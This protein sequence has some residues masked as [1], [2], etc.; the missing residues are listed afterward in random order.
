M[1]DIAAGPIKDPTNLTS[2]TKLLLLAQIVISVVAIVSGA[3]ELQML[4][5]F[6][7][8]TFDGDEDFSDAAD[9]NDLR[10]GIIGVLQG[11]IIL[12]SG[13]V[14][15]MW[16]YRANFNA[17]RLGAVGME[18]S[19]VWAVGWYFVPFAN[20]WKPYQAM[21]E[22]WKASAS[23]ERW[24]DEDRSWLLPVW[25]TVWI[26]SNIFD[27]VAFRMAFRDDPSLDQLIDASGVMLISDILDIPLALVFFVLVQKI[28]RMQM[29]QA[30]VH[31][32]S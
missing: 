11:L 23:P 29:E 6:Q 21:K 1:A 26:I 10:Q 32:F 7:A 14:I 2:W 17:R 28:H 27:N 16:I 5:D 9:A 18:F 13:V 25:W 3:F 22:I 31:S 20:L 24:E 15:L 19:P 30:Q 8:G 4:Q 12:S